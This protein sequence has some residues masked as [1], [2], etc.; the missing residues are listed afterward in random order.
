M[1]AP[2]DIDQYLLVNTKE[3]AIPQREVAFYLTSLPLYNKYFVHPL[4]LY[5]QLTFFLT[6]LMLY[7]HCSVSSLQ[8]RR[9]APGSDANFGV[10][11]QAGS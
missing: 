6:T 5:V 11:L 4:R 9:V 2:E 3:D 7:F 10:S 1:N 8:A